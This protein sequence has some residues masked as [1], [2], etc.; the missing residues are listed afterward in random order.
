M[1][2]QYKISDEEG[3]AGVVS[4]KEDGSF[5]L[6]D[7]AP[8]FQEFISEIISN[9]L[10]TNECLSNEKD[11]NISHFMIRK[12]ITKDEP[13]FNLALRDRLSSLGF[14]VVDMRTDIDEE[15]K[16]L[17]KSDNLDE[18]AKN[19]SSGLSN[20]TYLEKSFLLEKLK[21]N[22]PQSSIAG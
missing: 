15:L 17:I 5:E 12:K 13:L 3:L 14:Y 1:K 7:C 11:G 2:S 6:S 4:F 18:G 21:G 19:I 8:G 10:E 22:S 16:S 9:G 20:L